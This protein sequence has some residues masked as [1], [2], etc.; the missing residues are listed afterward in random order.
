MLTAF[1]AKRRNFQPLSTACAIIRLEKNIAYKCVPAVFALSF[2]VFPQ[3]L[4]YI[5]PFL[6]ISAFPA[7]HAIAI[8]TRV[9][10][11]N[12]ARA[13]SFCYNY[14][15]E[16]KIYT[17]DELNHVEKD[18]LVRTIL[19]LLENTAR[20]MENQGLIMGGRS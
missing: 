20:M 3:K 10:V 16:K 11:K 13:A 12:A 15:M 14:G 4:A 9:P 2:P 6:Y 7:I 1:C 5:I 18:E 8:L 17:A 19:S